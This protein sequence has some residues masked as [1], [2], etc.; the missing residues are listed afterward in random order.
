MPYNELA[1]RTIGFENKAMGYYVGLE[2]AYSDVLSGSSGKQLKR[3]INNGDW[4]PVTDKPEIEP[5]DGKDILT[6]IDVNIQD[7]A[8]QS[9][10]KC[11]EEH[12]A[13][14]GCAILME[15]ATGEIHAIANLRYDSIDHLYK[16]SYNYSIGASIE[17]GSTFKLASLIALLEDNKVKT[18]DL[19]EV[20][21]GTITFYNRTLRDVHKFDNEWVTFKQ[22]FEESSNVG[23]SRV[24]N[25]N[26]KEEPERYVAHLRRMNLD[27]KL[28]IEIPGEGKPFIKDPTNKRTWYGTTLPWMSVGYELMLTPLQLLTFYNAIANDGVMVKPMFV[29]E[30]QAGGITIEKYDTM[31]INPAICSASTLNIVQQL[32]EGVVENG[33][34]KSIKDSLFRIAGKTGTAQIANKNQGYSQRAYN[35]SFVG[36]FPADKPKYSCIVVVNRPSG[37]FYYGGSV[38]APVFKDIA[39]KV[40][41]YQLDINEIDYRIEDQS[42]QP[43]ATARGFYYDLQACF[44]GL[45]YPLGERQSTTDWSSIKTGED[46]MILTSLQFSNDT[47]PDLTGMS[48]KDALFLVEERG[49]IP[50]VHGKGLV[51]KQSIQA[52]STVNK[53]DQIIIQLTNGKS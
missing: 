37:S 15:V 8:E 26:Y 48:L 47:I 41:A 25:E 32:L 9:L 36:Y 46:G 44:T 4:I 27:N 14:Q 40:F 11:L 35:A 20:G 13:F 29:K 51:S 50:V 39:K 6:T 33:T 52:G 53:G 22:V 28:G 38:A 12:Q 24:V 17:P 31:V 49:L 45:E 18:S 1:R 34:A 43:P 23:V 42:T 30:I 16:E 7:V 21:N 19:I 2:G 10:L 5:E 3:K